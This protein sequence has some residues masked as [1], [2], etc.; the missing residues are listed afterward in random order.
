MERNT[1]SGVQ[2]EGGADVCCEDG[3][4]GFNGMFGVHASNKGSVVRASGCMIGV[5]GEKPVLCE[6]ALVAMSGCNVPK[7][8]LD[9]CSR[10]A[11]VIRVL[12]K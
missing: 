8:G 12:E 4:T 3:I 6:E 11:G 9:G 2:A 5:G 1:L 10:G 7:G